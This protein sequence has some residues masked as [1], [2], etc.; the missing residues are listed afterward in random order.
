MFA[1]FCEIQDGQAANL[2][3]AYGKSEKQFRQGGCPFV[4]L[5]PRETLV[6]LF[7]EP[8]KSL[9]FRVVGRA[10]FNYSSR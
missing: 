4:D 10:L 2:V 7:A 9:S 1:N 3:A 5:T 8:N 6:V